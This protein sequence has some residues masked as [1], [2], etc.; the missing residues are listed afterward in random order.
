MIGT[1]VTVAFFMATLVAILSVSFISFYEADVALENETMNKLI[2]VREI[3]ASQIED[4]FTQI[5]NQVVTFSEDVMIV[6]AMQAFTRTFNAVHEETGVSSQNSGNV[7]ASL[8]SSYQSGFIKSLGERRG[9]GV[10]LNEF[11]PKDIRTRVLQNLYIASNKNELGSKHLLDAQSD[12]S[13]YSK[14]HAKYHPAIRGFL[15]KFGYYDIFLIEPETGYIVYSV[16][17]EVDYATSL[18]RGPYRNTNL[19]EVVNEVKASGKKGFSKLVDFKPYSP[20]YD[21]PAAFIAAPIYDGSNLVGVLAFQMPLDKINEVMTSHQKWKDIGLG[22]S[23]ETYLVGDDLK[24]RSQSRFLIEDE[25]GY[26]DLMQEVGLNSTV[27]EKIKAAG[28]AIG[29]QPVETEATR[30]AIKGETAAEIV[31]DYRNI[32]VL[33]AYQPLKVQDMHW[34]IMSEIDEAEAFAPVYSLRNQILVT[35]IIVLIFVCSFALFFSSRMI[36]KP[37]KQML[38]AVDE[39][40]EGDGDLTYRLPDFGKDEIGQTASSL[41]GFIEKI[42]GVMLEVSSSVDNISSGSEEISA[43]AQSLSQGA[44][45]QAASIEETSASLE[46]MGAS[47]NQNSDNA[48]STDSVATKASTD[49]QEG[50]ESVAETVAA[51]K[52]IADKINIIEDIAYKT[53]LLA[54]NAAIEAARAGE[55]GKGFAVVAAEVRKLAE[56][57]QDSAQEISELASNSVRVAEKAGGL[58]AEIVPGIQK[59]AELVQEISAASE[60]QAAGIGQVNTAISQLDKVSQTNAAASEELAATSEEMSSQAVQLQDVVGFFKLGQDDSARP[61]GVM[62]NQSHQSANI[63]ELEAASGMKKTNPETDFERFG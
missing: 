3:K 7:D 61:G 23:G 41:N 51:M 8:K 47:I 42:Q 46:Q 25:K 37:I 29:L 63:H 35:A 30:A 53:N 33:S 62:R 5:R 19:A 13:S 18:D 40:R 1:K 17:K 10:N 43:T 27:I 24:L 14:T 50:G 21:A 16:F 22:D 2:A 20:S 48:K 60:E 56:R 32:P 9:R 11:Y 12:G 36:A 45:E 49:A 26:F 54:L 28:T 4:Y 52:N 44:T 15:E 59:T 58:L 6:D 38:S 55:H 31:N 57:S 39:L 34:A